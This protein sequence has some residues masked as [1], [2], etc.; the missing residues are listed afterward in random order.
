M[1]YYGFNREKLLKNEWDKYR[2][3]GSKKKLPSI[4]LITKK[5]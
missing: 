3:K 4:M 1:S 5:F 2:N